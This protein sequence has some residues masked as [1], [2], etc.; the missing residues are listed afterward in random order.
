MHIGWTKNKMYSR[1]KIWE[2]K[3]KYSAATYTVTRR[4]A[5][6]W[7]T[8]PPE[9]PQKQLEAI[10]EFGIRS[11]KDLGTQL[12]RSTTTNNS[13]TPNFWRSEVH[14][15]H[16]RK[17][18]LFGFIYSL[19]SKT[20]CIFSCVFLFLSPWYSTRPVNSVL[21]EHL[22]PGRLTSACKTTHTSF[23]LYTGCGYLLT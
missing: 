12:P 15:E 5:Q 2:K 14:T 10:K 11:F 17:I 13:F 20:S 23:W 18:P 3:W 9:F 19:F 6:G 7:K 16:R 22:Q 4:D 21:A 8:S 1:K